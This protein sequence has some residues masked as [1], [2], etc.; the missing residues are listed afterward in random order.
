[1]RAQRRKTRAAVMVI[2]LH[3]KEKIFVVFVF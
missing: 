1:M 2:F 3:V